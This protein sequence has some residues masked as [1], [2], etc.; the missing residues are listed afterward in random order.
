MV[1]LET[2][3]NHLDGLNPA[4]LE[5]VTAVHG[6]ILI[7]AGPGSGKTRVIVHRIANLILGEHISPYNVL[8][9]TFTNKAAREMQD[10]LGGLLGR[11]ADG[12]A[13]GTFHS[14]CSRILRRHGAMIGVDQHF[15]I[16]DDGDQVD[17][18]RR[19]LRDMEIDEKRFTPRSFLSAI[20]A[21][22]SELISPRQYAQ[23]AHGPWQERASVIYQRYQD[24]LTENH[25]LDFDDL[26]AETVRLFREAPD[27]LDAHQERFRYIMVDE[28]QDTNMAQYRLVR[29]LGQKY[30]NVCVVGDEDQSVYSWR[31]A[32]IRNLLNFEEDFP[33]RKVI[34]LEQNYRSTQ[35]ILDVAQAVISANQLRKNK[36]LWT[37]NERGR[38]VTIHEAYNEEDEAQYVIREIEKL[39]R[40]ERINY[41]D[42]AVMYRTN[43]QSRPIEDAFVRIGV[44]YKLIGGTRF[45]ERKEV[46]DVLAYLRLAVNSNDTA[47]LTRVLNVPPRGIGD[48]T[49]AEVQKWSARQGATFLEA[50]TAAGAEPDEGRNPILQG[51]ARTAVKSFVDLV[52]LLNRAS[53]ELSPLEL[54]DLALEHSG[55]AAHLRDGTENGEE[56]WANIMELRTKARDY[57]D[58]TRPMG[59]AVMLEEVTLVQDVDTFDDQSDGVTLITLHAA[60][61]LEF[62]YVFLVGMEEGLT[63]HSR[64]MDD[65][66]Q[67][68]EERRL[69]YVG[70]T[71][72]MRALYMVYAFRRT[73]YGASMVNQPSR[74]LSDIPPELVVRP[75]GRTEPVVAGA[76]RV[77][78]SAGGRAPAS[79]G[80]RTVSAGPARPHAYAPVPHP[81]ATPPPPAADQQYQPGDRV[82]HPSFGTGIVVTSAL[83][84]GDEELTV[85]F[86]GK[87][88]KKLSVAYAPLTRA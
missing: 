36:K 40:S 39:A 69:V 64:S 8:A 67:M 70:I 73:L 2:I 45:Y 79:A 41:R 9:V 47:S 24:S 83:V 58:L 46:K 19:I 53:L 78:S 68:E 28:F 81:S 13:V 49:V 54:L 31:K 87:G 61:G 16:Y 80:T 7:V 21:S 65:P 37:E 84:R 38:P 88:V 34:L 11:R 6:P 3:M 62:P 82:F 72:A 12:L 15:N 59:L 5:A 29:A 76:P 22:K 75:F 30:R 71:R 14:Q 56:R 32:D 44:P 55:Y 60:K 42:V 35:T 74:F 23:H 4:Q 27:V 10:R 43:A 33:E 1:A 77:P 20:S 57:A 50:L 51:R 63:P 86:E 66:A 26:I 48:R 17:L 18:V 85:A 25:A 52:A